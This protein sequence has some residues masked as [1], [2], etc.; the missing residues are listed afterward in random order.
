MYS[1]R[2]HANPMSFLLSYRS[3]AMLYYRMFRIVK[4]ADVFLVK[5]EKGN[6]PVLLL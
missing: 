3:A 6:F 4:S 5:K 2:R 1:K